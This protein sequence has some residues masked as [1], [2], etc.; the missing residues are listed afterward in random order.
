[1]NQD[2]LRAKSSEK[3]GKIMLKSLKGK[4]KRRI[5]YS[6]GALNQTLTLKN[7]SKKF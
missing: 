2:P 3:I 6:S 7:F 1:M 5:L 4:R